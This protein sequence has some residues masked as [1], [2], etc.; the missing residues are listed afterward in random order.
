VYVEN[1]LWGRKRVDKVKDFGE[2][3]SIYREDKDTLE[4]LVNQV[5]SMKFAK[6]LED[7]ND[8]TKM[9]ARRVWSGLQFMGFEVH[10]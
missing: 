8:L 7:L 6:G 5:C 3:F 10:E 1:F 2:E 9:G 4:I